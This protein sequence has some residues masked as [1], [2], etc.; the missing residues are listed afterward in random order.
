[1][2]LILSVL[3]EIGFKEKL[4]IYI[5]GEYIYNKLLGNPIDSIE[6]ILNDKIENIINTLMKSL[7]KVQMII[8]EENNIIKVTHHN[9]IISLRFK[10]INNFSIKDELKSRPFTINSMAVNVLN[11]DNLIHDNIID[12]FNSYEDIKNKII[13]H[14]HINVF[15]NNPINILR[16]VVLMSELDFSLSANTK[17]LIKESKDNVNIISGKKAGNEIFKILNSSKSSYYFRYMDKELNI[18]DI[19]FPEIKEMRCVGECNYHVVDVLTHSFL[20]L[21]IIEDIIYSKGY[22]E[23]HIRNVLEKHSDKQVSSYHKRFHLIKLGAFF[24]DVGKSLAKKVDETGRIRFKGH[25]ITGAEIVKNIAQRMELSIKERDILYR[26]VSSHMVPL[27]LYKQNDVSGKLLYKMF[28]ELKEDTLDVCLISLADII[29]TRKLLNPSED[30][31]KFK[32]H[33]EYIV[34]NYL[35]RFKEVEDISKIIKGSEIIKNFDLDEEIMVED[36]IEE[37]RKAIYNGK[38]ESKKEEVLRYINKIL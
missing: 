22:F 24:H 35:T 23:D 37:V 34:N 29:A 27:V 16:A 17:E 9:Q 18:L 6:V 31:G 8:R 12:P 4:E 28:N 19:V 15:K 14:S 32:I 36:L 7:D 38:I 2:D 1:M 21:E 25:E 20:T 13:R 26:L 3:K 11:Y 33:I 10:E 30:M 5:V